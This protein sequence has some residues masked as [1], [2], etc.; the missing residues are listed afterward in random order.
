MS[1]YYL[2]LALDQAFFITVQLELGFD[3][4]KGIANHTHHDQQASRRDQQQ[5]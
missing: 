5:A 4:G 3:D 2:R 1:A